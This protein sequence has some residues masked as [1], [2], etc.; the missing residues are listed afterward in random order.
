MNL[1]LVK[2]LG[3]VAL[4]CSV[5]MIGCGSDDDDGGSGGSGGG[6]SGTGGT[7]G[8]GGSSGSGGTAGSSGSGGTAGSSGSGG[9]AGASGSAGS[10]GNAGAGGGSG[11]DAFCASYDTKCGFGTADHFADL[12]T[13]KTEFESKLT[14]TRRSCIVQH[15][16]L[17][18]SKTSDHC[19]HAAGA[20]P[21]DK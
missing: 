20:A 7:A 14:G 12:A 16:G 13:C 21:C 10:A 5:G 2:T 3:F 6:T 17:A 8:S 4:T 1:N 9:T 15:L 19:K 18:D 11:A